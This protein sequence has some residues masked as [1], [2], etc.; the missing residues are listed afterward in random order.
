MGV[1]IERKFLVKGDFSEGLERADRIVQGYLCTAPDKTIRIRIREGKAFLTIKDK[2]KN[3]SIA[4]SEFEYEIP[5]SDAE[6]LLSL[7]ESGVIEKVRHLVP[8]QGHV[9]EV[10]VFH[11]CNEGLILA[12]IEL[13]GED[14]A[15]ELPAW[16]GDEVTGDKLYYN[17]ML[18]QYPYANWL[19]EEKRNK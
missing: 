1:E 17:S 10:D 11:G 4:R 18:S 15:F 2:A 16:V 8:Y 7:C 19:P 6:A 9:W 14:E 5:V 12:E 13:T 3:D